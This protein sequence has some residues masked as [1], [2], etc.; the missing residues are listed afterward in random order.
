MLARFSFSDYVFLL[1]VLLSLKQRIYDWTDFSTCYHPLHFWSVGS[2]LLAVAFRA[3]QVLLFSRA[4][5]HTYN[6]DEQL[7]LTSATSFS[8]HRDNLLRC[9]VLYI[10]FALFFAWTVTG[11]V[12][13]I[14]VFYYTPTCLPPT[15]PMFYMVTWLIVCYCWISVYICL[16]GVALSYEYRARR[17]E[18]LLFS[19]AAASSL[20]SSAAAAAGRHGMVERYDSLVARWG[21]TVSLAEYGVPFVRQGLTPSQVD[22]L[23]SLP[24]SACKLAGTDVCSICIDAFHIGTA[25][26]VLEPCGHMFHKVCIDGWLL[27]NAVCPNCKGLIVSPAD[28]YGTSSTTTA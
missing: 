15:C 2:Q 25:V 20:P 28:I 8:T 27:R 21:R 7:Q 12:W 17:A 6:Q 4:S 1:A 11:N 19:E 18:S 9:T 23:P 22:A 26:R 5:I 14:Q 10:L 3:A 16:I 13:I 24:C